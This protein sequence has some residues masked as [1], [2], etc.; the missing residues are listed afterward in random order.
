MKETSVDGAAQ[1]RTVAEQSFALLYRSHL[2]QL[3]DLAPIAVENDIS[4]EAFAEGHI[5][6]YGFEK[7]VYDNKKERLQQLMS[8]YSALYHSDFGLA[9]MVKSDGSTFD[10]AVGVRTLHSASIPV[11]PG[12]STHVATSG[13][14]LK[15]A[16]DGNFSGTQLDLEDAEDVHHRLSEGFSTKNAK[17]V[18]AIIGNP[19]VK[20]KEGQDFVQSLDRVLDGLRGRKFTLLVLADPVPVPQILSAKSGFEDFATAISVSAEQS[21]LQSVHNPWRL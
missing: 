13:Q 5:R 3:G 16:F 18:A 15:R 19:S 7:I 11:S 17:A 2:D 21:W 9:F 12:F 6:F 20:T 8:C 4:V 14:T 10:I 1:F